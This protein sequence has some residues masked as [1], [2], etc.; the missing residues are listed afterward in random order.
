[1]AGTIKVEIYKNK[2]AEEFTTSLA[3]AGSRLDTGGGAAMCAAV[4]ASFLA[5]AAAL[6]AAGSAESEQLDYIVRNAEILRKYMVHLIDEDVRSRGPLRRAILEGDAQKIDAAG[7][8]AVSISEEIVN[9]MGKC[10]D[11]LSELADLCVEGAKHYVL[12]GAEI[13]MAAIR[14]SMRYILHMSSGSMDE[15][16]RYITRRENEITLEQSTE[17]YEAILAKLAD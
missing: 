11:L 9:M 6:T 17:V 14:A 10:L 12:E 8:S 15:T 3:D 13:A 16:Y 1:M 7:Q 2:N 5:R 4:A